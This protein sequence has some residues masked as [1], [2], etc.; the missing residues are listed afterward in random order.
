MGLSGPVTV[1]SANGSAARVRT[2]GAPSVEAST[3]NGSVDLGFTVAPDTVLATSDNGS[4]EVR[5]PEVDGDYR[6]DAGH[7]QRLDRDRGG[8]GSGLEP[9]R[10]APVR[11]RRPAGAAV[12]ERG[13]V[14]A[15]LGPDLVASLVVALGGAVLLLLELVERPEDDGPVSRS[16]ATP[17][18]ASSNCSHCCL[19][20]CHCR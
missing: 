6:V 19:P 16:D 12:G 1:H 15:W 2:C 9:L 14:I 11:Q 5:L 17:R 4:V 18:T 8:D 20:G 10:G 7:R 13:P 3:E